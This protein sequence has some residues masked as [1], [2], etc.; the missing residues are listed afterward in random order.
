MYILFIF[1]GAFGQDMKE[2]ILKI[3]IKIILTF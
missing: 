3:T 2:M 1:L